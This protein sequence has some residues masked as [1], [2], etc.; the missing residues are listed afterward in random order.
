MPS[1]RGDLFLVFLFL[2][3]RWKSEDFI[4]T[5]GSDTAKLVMSGVLLA[6]GMVLPFLTGQ[7]P[8]IGSKLS[9]L[10]LPVLVCGFICG[11]K[12]GLAVGFILPLLRS[13]TFGMPPL[14]PTAS[15]MAV[16]MA[17]YGAVTG[18]LYEWLPKKNSSVYIAL[19]AAMLCGRIAWGLACVPLNGIAGKAFSF[20]IFL[21]SGFINAIP[22][23][24]LQLIL[25]PLIVMA[26]KRSGAMAAVQV[27]KG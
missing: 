16:E 4:M 9:P 19:I 26:L 17:V 22:A 7:I 21:A 2:L 25:V 18:L 5:K 1:L 14:M 20:Q 6:I 24:T 23:I 13:V 8:E 3:F 10:H 11:W 15:A 27:R 12:Y